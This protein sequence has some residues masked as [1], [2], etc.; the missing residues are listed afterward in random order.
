MKRRRSVRVRSSEEAQN[1]CG[2][3]VWGKIDELKG[4]SWAM[5]RII[6]WQTMFG[7]GD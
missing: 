2:M 3:K 5:T 1:S 7:A 4:E 6:E